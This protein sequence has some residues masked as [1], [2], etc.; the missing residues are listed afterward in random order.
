MADLKIS[1]R[2]S[3]FQLLEALTRNR[4]HRL[5]EHRFVVQGVR[6][7]S[8]AIEHGWTLLTVIHDAERSL[9][10]WARDVL[11]QAPETIS[12]SSALLA[13]LA[14]KDEGATEIL[15]VVAMPEDELSR[16]PVPADFLGMVFDRPTQPGNIGAILRSMDALG[17]QG[18]I[19]SGHAADPYDPKSVRASTG[20]LFATPVVRTASGGPVF[21]WVRDI[22]ARGIPLTLVATD[23]HGDVD[24][25]DYDFT[26]PSLVLIGNETGGLAR[27]WREAA[28]VMV[29]VPMVGAA[30]SL[31]ASN[32]ATLMLYEAARQRAA[33]PVDRRGGLS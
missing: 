4:N 9:S 33:R 18:L 6:P 17:G 8:Q 25:W 16:I 29:R 7:I 31:N 13:E 26:Q 21:D 3:R 14:E 19:V 2:N 20:S 5:R 28:D 22:R 15:A 27:G 12:M 23:E 32:A 24:V 1:T 10:S 30:S 11:K